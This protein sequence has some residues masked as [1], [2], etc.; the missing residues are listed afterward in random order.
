MTQWLICLFFFPSEVN[1]NKINFVLLTLM[2]SAVIR[3]IG[4]NLLLRSED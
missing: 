1:I 4:T 2:G 3:Y